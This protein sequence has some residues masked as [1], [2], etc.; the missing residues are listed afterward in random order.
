MSKTT[1]DLNCILSSLT[2]GEV[3]NLIYHQDIGTKPLVG[4][5]QAVS[6]LRYNGMISLALLVLHKDPSY[7]SEKAV[8]N[9]I[10]RL[11]QKLIESNGMPLGRLMVELSAEL[12]WKEAKLEYRKRGLQFSHLSDSGENSQCQ[13]LGY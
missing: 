12:L 2:N 3:R 8:E 5:R 6:R 10:V 11:K 9:T 7:P 13:S 1:K 4:I